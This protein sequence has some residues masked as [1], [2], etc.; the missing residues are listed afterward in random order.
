M[1]SGTFTVKNEKDL[2]PKTED[3]N[4]KITQQIILLK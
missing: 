3:V 4:K 2:F 1:L